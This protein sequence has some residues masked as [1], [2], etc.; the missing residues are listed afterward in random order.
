[1][2]NTNST[3]TTLEHKLFHAAASALAVPVDHALERVASFRNAILASSNTDQGCATI[4]LLFSLS[5]PLHGTTIRLSD[6]ILLGILT[7]STLRFTGPLSHLNIYVFGH[8]QVLKIDSETLTIDITRNTTAPTIIL[9]NRDAK[10]IVS[11]SRYSLCYMHDRWRPISKWTFR[12]QQTLAMAP[13]TQPNVDDASQADVA[14]SQ[15]N[16]N[17][18]QTNDNVLFVPI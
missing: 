16:A 3:E 7:R 12:H 2:E 11:R 15:T 5:I 9:P 8:S 17:L 4:A 18:S 1:M 13:Q 14:A 6:T 10:K